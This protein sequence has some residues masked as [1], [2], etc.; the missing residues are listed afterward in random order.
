MRVS[1]ALVLSFLGA[2]TGFEPQLLTAQQQLPKASVQT[3]PAPGQTHALR[4]DVLAGDGAKNATQIHVAVQPVLQI[5]DNRNLPVA[6]AVVTLECP[7][8]GPGVVFANGSRSI[9]LVSEMEGRVVLHGAT[10]VGLGPFEIAI[11]ASYNNYV[12]SATIHQTNF[13]T[14]A[15]AAAARLP[16]NN[17]AG[18]SLVTQQ[19]SSKGIWIGVG[20]AMAIG[21]GL[22]IY[23]GTRGHN[24]SSSSISVGTPSVGA[25]K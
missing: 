14:A 9:S 22:G 2:F 12:A 16:P 19:H 18:R 17:I 24:S 7:V 5:L 1:I 25:P 4:V 20:V 6:G 15:D 8:A 23:F 10:P 13:R 3:A 11:T 21:V